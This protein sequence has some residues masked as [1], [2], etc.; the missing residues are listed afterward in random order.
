MPL[1][2][3]PNI[4]QMDSSAGL[5]ALSWTESYHL[6]PHT[7]LVERERALISSMIQKSFVG[8]AGICSKA[9]SAVAAL[10]ALQELLQEGRQYF[11]EASVPSCEPLSLP[12]LQ[13]SQPNTQSVENIFS[14]RRGLYALGKM[15]GFE[16]ILKHTRRN[17]K[18]TVLLECT[19]FQKEQVEEIIVRCQELGAQRMERLHK[20]SH[21][22]DA[23]VQMVSKDKYLRNTLCAIGGMT[24]GEKFAQSRRE[25]G[26]RLTKQLFERNAAATTAHSAFR[27]VFNFDDWINSLALLKDSF[28]ASAQHYSPVAG[29]LAEVLSPERTHGFMRTVI[30]LLDDIAFLSRKHPTLVESPIKEIFRIHFLLAGLQKQLPTTL[31]DSHNKP[32]ES[33]TNLFLQHPD[34]PAYIIGIE[35]DNLLPIQ[36]RTLLLRQLAQSQPATPPA[37]PV[38]E[39]MHTVQERRTKIRRELKESL[40]LVR[41]KQQVQEVMGRSQELKASS[42]PQV[43]R[44]DAT[45]RFF[46][47]RLE[48]EFH[49]WASD[50]QDF[51][52][53]GAHDLLERATKGERVDFKLIP[54]EKKMFELRLIGGGG[55]GI[56]IY[57]TRAKNSQVIVLGFGTKTS[58]KQDILTAYD[59]YRNLAAS[60]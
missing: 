8:L 47:P 46:P 43:P 27:P 14:V 13:T 54:I 42:A 60:E 59:R 9:A 29:K 16:K 1:A 3:P 21:A 40:E 32:P 7:M 50:F 6:S 25:E 55:G 19:V 58:Q 39:P 24:D 56:R 17:L 12:H 45:T 52:L 44:Y 34:R 49:T 38:S 5:I 2:S 31:A 18:A 20:V 48:H 57:C 33:V 26:P 23:C 30:K 35:C 4:P 37:P 53:S 28:P 41:M 15:E 51:V 36:E 22:L 10:N 11:F